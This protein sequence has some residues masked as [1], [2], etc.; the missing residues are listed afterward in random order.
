MQ[1]AEAGG[2]ACVVM[3]QNAARRVQSVS[4]ELAGVLLNPGGFFFF[5]VVPTTLSKNCELGPSWNKSP[6]FS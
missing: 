5:H 6:R 4:G 1:R 2:G 3:Q